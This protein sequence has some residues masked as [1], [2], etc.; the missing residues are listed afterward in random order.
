M[1]VVEWKERKVNK[2]SPEGLG[3]KSA[4]FSFSYRQEPITCYRPFLV[5]EPP[6]SILVSIHS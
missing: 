6:S 2:R 3:V 5:P 1:S 4:P